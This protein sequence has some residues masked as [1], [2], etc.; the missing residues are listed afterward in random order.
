M[1]KRALYSNLIDFKPRIIVTSIV[2][3][4]I[5]LINVAIYFKYTLSHSAE[6][7]FFFNKAF[8]KGHALVV[9]GDS[10]I[11]S[12]IMIRLLGIDAP[13]LHQSCGTSK[14]RYPCGLKAKK[15]LEKLIARKPV[16]CYW[17]KKDKYHRILAT[18][19]TE[20]INNINATM[21][22]DGWAIS[23]YDYR[24][25]ERKAKKQ[26]K[27]IWQSSFQKPQEWRK[28]HSHINQ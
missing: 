5:F 7:S 20:Q 6:V 9:D 11:I 10:I 4:T 12:S 14:K 2:I 13:E 24:K 21:V 28:A 23:Y 17:N 3:I 16:T 26:K 18:C 15:H 19:K 27:G 25:E 1:K 22:R 8:L